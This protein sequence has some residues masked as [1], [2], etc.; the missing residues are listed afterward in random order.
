MWEIDAVCRDCWQKE[1]SGG[2]VEVMQTAA[3]RLQ[4]KTL[5]LIEQVREV[6]EASITAMTVRQ[7]FYQ[8][9]VREY[10]E[11][12]RSTYRKLG[13]A[14]VEARLQ[15]LI[16]WERIEDRLRKPRGVFMYSSLRTY[17]VVASQ[18]Y[19]RDIWPTQS[20]YVHVWLEKD[21]LSGIFE[22]ALEPYRL[23][24]NVGR[25]YDSWSSIREAAERFRQLRKPVKVLYFGDFDPS[26]EQMTRSLEERLRHLGVGIEMEIVRVAIL[27]Q[28]IARY[29]LPPNKLKKEDPRTEGF[30]VRHGENASVELDALPVDVL[31]ERLI[32]SVEANLDLEQ[33]SSIRELE[34]KI[35]QRISRALGRIRED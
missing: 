16:D 10:I 29:H 31:R 33:L 1:A 17:A 26:G 12:S 34:E 22:D 19:Y 20:T 4:K 21:A 9:V 18:N 13:R 2:G 24:L 6:L 30:R 8:L 35:R 27:K 32:A 28:D 3:S 23:L 7:C 11:N 25:G 5:A 15:G 14:L